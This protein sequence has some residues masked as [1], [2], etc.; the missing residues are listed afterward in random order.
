MTNP[1]QAEQ[2]FNNGL[3]CAQ[4]VISI[5]SDRFKLL[6]ETALQMTCGFG[7]G[8]ARMQETCGAITGSVMVIGLF[9]AEKKID[10]ADRKEETYA[11]ITDFIKHFR[12]RNKFITCRDLLKCD[13]NTEE[14]RYHYDVNEL[15]EKV[16]LKCVKDAVK[17]L[18]ELFK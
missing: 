1:E 7:A 2:I 3:N 6:N 9:V 16:C 10:A 14:G 15:H 18:D 13:I 17:I 4:A 11:M 8:I 5:Y 12:D